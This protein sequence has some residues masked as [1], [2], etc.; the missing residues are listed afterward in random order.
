[1]EERRQVPRHDDEGEEPVERRDR[2][3]ED[4]RVLVRQGRQSNHWLAAV[5]LPQASSARRDY[6]GAAQGAG[7]SRDEDGTQPVQV[8]ARQRQNTANAC[9]EALRTTVGRVLIL[10]PAWRRVLESKTRP[11]RFSRPALRTTS[12]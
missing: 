5:P 9:A 1:A 12:L 4:R 7:P 10:R 2:R 6:R 3:S 11:T 8:R